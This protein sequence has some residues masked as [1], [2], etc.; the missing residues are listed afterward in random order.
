[1]AAA[2]SCGGVFD[3]ADEEDRTENCHDDDDP[4]D[5]GGGP[6]RRQQRP[7]LEARACFR[8]EGR[9]RVSFRRRRLTKTKKTATPRSSRCTQRRP[10]SQRRPRRRR[11]REPSVAAED[12]DDERIIEPAAFS[13]A[14][15]RHVPAGHGRRVAGRTG[16]TGVRRRHDERDGGRVVCCHEIRDHPAGPAVVSDGAQNHGG[17]AITS[18]YDDSYADSSSVVYTRR[19]VYDWVRERVPVEDLLR[20]PHSDSNNDDS[21]WL[22]LSVH[23]T[24]NN[25]HCLPTDI[26]HSHYTALQVKNAL[27]DAARDLD[28]ENRS[29]PSVDTT[30]AVDV[31]LV[32]VLRGIAGDPM[33]EFAARQWRGAPFLV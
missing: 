28:D 2:L 4:T 7:W 23:V 29:R 10:R 19:D 30:D 27:V 24:L 1:M 32:A 31:P 14:L 21:C 6:I 8:Q 15:P 17:A 20:R 22:T 25:P 9:T 18:E 13:L 16:G 5:D 12:Y 11:R 33:S 26:N 3:G